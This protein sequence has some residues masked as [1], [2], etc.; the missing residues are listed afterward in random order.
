MSNSA[1]EV[2]CLRSPVQ[3]ESEV[4]D[5]MVRVIGPEIGI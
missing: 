2:H 5:G 3:T 1:A 4:K